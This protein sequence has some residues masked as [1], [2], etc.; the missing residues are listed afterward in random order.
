MGD[1]SSTRLADVVVV[2]LIGFGFIF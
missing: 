2:S 1:G